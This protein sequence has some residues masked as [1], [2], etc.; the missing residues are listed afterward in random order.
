M[1][2]VVLSS[3]RTPS[4][5]SR[6]ATARL[7]AAFGTPSVRAAAENPLRST[8][9]ASTASCAG[10]QNKFITRDSLA[11]P[12]VGRLASIVSPKKRGRQSGGV[13]FTP[14]STLL[15]HRTHTMK[16]SMYTMAVEQNA[17]ML[18]NLSGLLDKGIAFAQ[19]KKFDS[20]VL[21]NSRLA[22]DMFPLSKQ[23]QI[24]C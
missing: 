1:R 23:V 14:L 7:T 15:P 18:Q 13:E 2:R 8:T 11:S 3:T 21:V 10:A 19:A 24:A 16:I 5:F 20:S 17:R 6:S 9:L 22:P 12:M 4:A